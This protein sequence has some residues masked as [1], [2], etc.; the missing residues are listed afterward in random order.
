MNIQ[1][2]S[3]QKNFLVPDN[4]IT[5]KG[6]LVQC[7]SCGNKWTQ[8]PPKNTQNEE[9]IETAQKMQ[10]TKKIKTIKQPKKPKKNKK[11]IDTYSTEYLQKKHGIRIIDP[12]S[13]KVDENKKV[14][15]KNKSKNI[16]GF[17]SYLLILGI[18]I[19]SLFG[20]LNLTKE[21]LILNFPFLEIYILNLYE[22]LDNIKLTFQDIINN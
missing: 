13:L 7:S 9:K 22:T 19:L 8:Y 17:Y 16:F 3:C 14:N 15:K 2:N 12:S 10:T 5:A 6:R 20:I 1:C 21:I 11:N 18:F 4:A